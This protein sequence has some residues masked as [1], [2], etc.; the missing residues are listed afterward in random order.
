MNYTGPHPDTGEMGRQKVALVPADSL[1]ATNDFAEASRLAEET[2]LRVAQVA[3]ERR[4]GETYVG[5]KSVRGLS[6]LYC[7]HLDEDT[8]RSRKTNDGM[9]QR[10][11]HLLQFSCLGMENDIRTLT[12]QTVKRIKRELKASMFVPVPRYPYPHHP[13]ANQVRVLL[14]ELRSFVSW[15]IEN[16]VS[17]LNNFVAQ[18]SALK[19]GRNPRRKN[20][21]F[22]HPVQ[23]ANI[24]RS[25]WDLK[26]RADAIGNREI[27]DLYLY[28]G[29]RQCEPLFLRPKDVNFETGIVRITTAKQDRFVDEEREWFDVVSP[30]DVDRLEQRDFRM[31]PQLYASLW[32]YDQRYDITKDQWP[33]FFPALGAAGFDLRDPTTHLKRRVGPYSFVQTAIRHAQLTDPTI[34][35]DG[36]HKFRHTYISARLNMYSPMVDPETRLVTPVEVSLPQV[37]SEVGHIEGSSVTIRTYYKTGYRVPPNM[38]FDLDWEDLAARCVEAEQTYKTKT[39]GVP[40]YIAERFK[41]VASHPSLLP[42]LATL[43]VVA[44]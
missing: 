39:A 40:R 3:A 38:S 9:K 25:A 26:V 41:P 43:P 11:G 16:H 31:W 1:V 12:T 14:R 6:V 30:D 13:S 21:F 33:W 2:W 42:C 22:Y 23:V 32:A 36:L 28:S 20:D 34:V 24:R 4:R 17:K 29:C 18:S 7:Q 10:I 27:L 19:G 15:V 5:P 37:Q 8:T 35:Y 44:A